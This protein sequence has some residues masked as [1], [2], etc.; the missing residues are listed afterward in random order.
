MTSKKKTPGPKEAARM[1]LLREAL[2]SRM[3]AGQ[4]EAAVS[5]LWRTWGSLMEIVCLSEAALAAAPGMAPEDAR[6]LHLCLELVRACMDEQAQGVKR[7]ADGLT[8][9]ELFRPLFL[10][11]RTEA[12]AAI[13]LDSSKRIIY[14]GIVCEGEVSA[15]PLY[16]RSLVRLCLDYDTDG[17]I[18]AH[19]HPSGVV[20]PSTQDILTT[21]QLG[22]TL[23]CIQVRLIDHIILTD[24]DSM[25]FFESGILGN[26]YEETLK[27]R[28]RELA[29]ALEMAG[30]MEEI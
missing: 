12:V 9:V 13:L 8:A 21:S 4:A 7:V 5:F 10:G 2:E 19:N 16:V 11:R 24:R 28:R 17:I 14:N 20:E 18:L 22:L 23:G 27:D 26:D 30:Q 15:V 6:Y 1:R 3:P 29:N 25:S